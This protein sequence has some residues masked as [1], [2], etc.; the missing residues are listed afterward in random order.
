MYKM[1]HNKNIILFGEIFY[2]KFKLNGIELPAL[3]EDND[4]KII[5]RRCGTVAISDLTRD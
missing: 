4:S 5:V 3:S 2:G 1:P